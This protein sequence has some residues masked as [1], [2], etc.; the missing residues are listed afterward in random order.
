[1]TQFNTNFDIAPRTHSQLLKE[2]NI[3]KISLRKKNLRQIREYKHTLESDFIRICKTARNQLERGILKNCKYD[4]F[5]PFLLSW[6]NGQSR[7]LD[8]AV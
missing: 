3:R 2:K 6:K 1:M 5:E 4:E 8:V 7:P